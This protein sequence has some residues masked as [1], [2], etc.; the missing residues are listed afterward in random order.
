MRRLA[1]RFP[2]PSLL[3]P[4]ALLLSS[5]PPARAAEV[6]VL[7]GSGSPSESWGTVWGGMLTISL[8]NI[9][10]GEIEGAHQ[11][12]ELEGGPSLYTAA[13]KAYLGPSIG[14][15]VP[16]GGIGAGVYHES[17]PVNDDQG[18]TGL[19]FAGAKLKFPFG[20]V[21]RAEYQ[22]VSMPDAAPVKLEHR[23]FFAAGLS[24]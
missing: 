9:V 4:L 1:R 13:A 2:L 16:Y 10:Y 7:V 23:Y 15:L 17:L 20:L 22:W 8:F 19:V 11:G 12:A 3:V 6:S 21:L 24:F 5:A 14:R 18:T